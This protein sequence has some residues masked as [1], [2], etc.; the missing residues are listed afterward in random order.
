M[1]MSREEL[2]EHVD[3]EICDHVSRFL[4]YDRKED[5]YLPRG[6][7]EKAI[8]DGDITVDEIV[9]AFAKWLRQ[10]LKQ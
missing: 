10:G 5:E 9:E 2:R 1:K 3:A 6:A 4:Y 7:L 8:E